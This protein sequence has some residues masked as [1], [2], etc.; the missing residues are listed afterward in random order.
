MSNTIYFILTA[1]IIIFFINHFYN[2]YF[3]RCK[4]AEKILLFR[5]ELIKL[6]PYF[7]GVTV[8]SSIDKVQ[9]NNKNFYAFIEHSDY[10]ECILWESKISI[11]IYHK[12]TFDEVNKFLC[13]V[14]KDI[15][16]QLDIL[17]QIVPMYSANHLYNFLT[18]NNN[19]NKKFD[20]SKFV[21][22]DEPTP[23]NIA[24]QDFLQ[25][26]DNTK[27]I[28][29]QLNH[30]PLELD[31]L[32]DAY[33]KIINICEDNNITVCPLPPLSNT[34]NEIVGIFIFSH[35]HDEYINNSWYLI[36]EDYEDTIS[37]FDM[38]EY[39]QQDILPSSINRIK[40]IDMKIFNHYLLPLIENRIQQTI[41]KNK[42]IK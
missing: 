7:Q 19:I 35:N 13:D 12:D 3:R 41:E 38:Y 20:Q 36:G 40:M 9:G 4:K 18:P 14:I 25:K 27:K 32:N 10:Y 6:L 11:T 31:E 28:N 1:S 23:L 39:I 29:K 21:F 2:E 16:Y 37:L 34:S 24:Y 5:R 8:C 15:N 42:N 30:I 26:V 33:C 17:F 22:P